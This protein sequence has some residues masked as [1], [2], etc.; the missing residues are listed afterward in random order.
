ML[1]FLRID[2]KEI[3]ALIAPNHMRKERKINYSFLEKT[4]G[5]DLERWSI[6]LIYDNFDP[7]L[8]GWRNSCENEKKSPPPSSNVFFAENIFNSLYVHRHDSLR[9]LFRLPPRPVG[10]RGSPP[11]HGGQHGRWTK[12]GNSNFPTSNFDF[13]CFFSRRGQVL[14]LEG[15]RLRGIARLL[16]GM[17]PPGNVPGPHRMR[18]IHL[19][20]FRPKE[21][22]WETDE[23]FQKCSVT[24]EVLHSEKMSLNQVKREARTDFVQRPAATRYWNKKGGDKKGPLKWIT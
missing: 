22:L 8:S 12:A 9:G 17:L 24:I 7:S 23:L 18:S 3:F 20:P 16:H 21:R 13:V 19:S 6:R 2:P 5:C 15:L 11:G 4:L 1:N 14:L 10:G